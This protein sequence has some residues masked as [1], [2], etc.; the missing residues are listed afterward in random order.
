MEGLFYLDKVV[1]DLKLALP[2][3]FDARR[4]RS[5]GGC[6]N[7]VEFLTSELSIESIYY[8]LDASQKLFSDKDDVNFYDYLESK[9]GLT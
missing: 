3:G 7:T 6:E 2:A 4:C 1:K 8:N 9:G 5:A